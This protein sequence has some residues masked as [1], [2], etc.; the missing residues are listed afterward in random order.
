MKVFTRLLMVLVCVSALTQCKVND[1]AQDTAPPFSPPTELQRADY[2]KYYQAYRSALASNDKSAAFQ[3]LEVAYR[4]SKVVYPPDSRELADLYMEVARLRREMGKEM[5]FRANLPYRLALSVYKKLDGIHSPSL[6]EPLIGAAET[7]PSEAVHVKYI[8]EVVA[9]AKGNG[10]PRLLAQTQIQAF[11]A[12]RPNLKQESSYQNWLINAEKFLANQQP[13]DPIWDAA[14]QRIWADIHLLKSEFPQAEQQYSGVVTK[15]GHISAAK[16]DVLK[17]RIGLFSIYFRKGNNEQATEQVVALGA[18]Q[19]MDVNVPLVRV[20]H[21]YPEKELQQGI[22]GNATL[23]FRVDEIGV[24]QDIK[25]IETTGSKS[26]GPA[27]VQALQQW[28]FVPKF[29]NGR[30]VSYES[31]IILAFGQ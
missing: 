22:K 5:F 9:V 13:R 25:I 7:A 10:D 28:R 26:F 23:A 19:A 17:A 8:E 31:K 30:A 16:Q 1:S 24:V 15:Y 21:K 18:M 20:E 3:Q 27:A 4:K 6:I 29:E 11:D 12:L 2:Q 14:I